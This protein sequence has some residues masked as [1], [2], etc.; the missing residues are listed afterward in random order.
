MIY[1][2]YPKVELPFGKDNKWFVYL[3]NSIFRVDRS[4]IVYDIEDVDEVGAS[5]VIGTKSH[6]ER[7]FAYELYRQWM[8]LLD[9]QGVRNLIVNGEVRKILKEQFDNGENSNSGIDDKDVFP[10]LVLHQSQGSDN[11]QIMVCEIKREE[12]LDS[13]GNNLFADLHKL[14][15]YINDDIFWK[16]PFPYG[17]FILE[18]KDANLNKLKI[19]SGTRTKFKEK[20]ISIEEFK[21]NEQIKKIVCLSYDGINLNYKTLDKLIDTIIVD[22]INN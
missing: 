6:L 10:D 3:F 14:S 15:C 12:G 13:T 2:P 5:K 18:G 20:D 21:N 11:L 4:F 1:N 9:E 7:V 19:K 8:N 16:K 17:V 22:E